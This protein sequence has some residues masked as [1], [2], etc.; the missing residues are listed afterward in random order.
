MV[1]CKA[2]R[3]PTGKDC[4]L[5]PVAWKLGHDRGSISKPAAS[6]VD[7]RWYTRRSASRSLFDTFYELTQV[8]LCMHAGE[9]LC[10]RALY[11]SLKINHSRCAGVTVSLVRVRVLTCSACPCLFRYVCW[12]FPVWFLSGHLQFCTCKKLSLL[13]LSPSLSSLFPYIWALV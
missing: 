7:V 9:V 5:V 2:D 6:I 1:T 13:P 4:L 3:R 11:H 12:A 10:C 8:L